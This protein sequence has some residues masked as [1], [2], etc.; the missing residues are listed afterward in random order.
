[1]DAA[2]KRLHAPLEVFPQ[3]PVIQHFGVLHG[4]RPDFVQEFLQ[5]RLPFGVELRRR[6]IMGEQQA[7][8]RFGIGEHSLM[9]LSDRGQ[10]HRRV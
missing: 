3:R 4:P 2:I 9:N 7:F 1:M 8:H 6:V 10:H 5:M